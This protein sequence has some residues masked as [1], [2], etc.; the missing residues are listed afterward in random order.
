MFICKFCNQSFNGLTPSQCGVHSKDCDSNPRVLSLLKVKIQKIESDIIKYG[1][2][3]K[4]IMSNDT[5]KKLSI[6]QKQFLLDNPDK[7]PWRYKKSHP[8][9]YLK[10]FFQENNIEF[11]SEYTVVEGRNYSG[12][13]VFP[14]KRIVIEVNGAQ[15]YV[16]YKLNNPLAP[17]YQERHDLMVKQGWKVVEVPCTNVY[18]EK[19]RNDLLSLINNGTDY[20]PIFIEKNKKVKKIKTRKC[21]QCKKNN[22][23]SGKIC[24]E[25]FSLNEIQNIERVALILEMLKTKSYSYV[26]KLYKVSSHTIIAWIRK[27]KCNLPKSIFNS[28]RKH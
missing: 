25:C 1:F 13:I 18:I 8:C 4:R 28:G 24:K 23:I 15:H 19:C 26:S 17:Y 3:N 2:N 14:A 5:K 21:K 10:K 11:E 27:A 12:D 7:H 6:Y 20:E 9:E 16:D 22:I